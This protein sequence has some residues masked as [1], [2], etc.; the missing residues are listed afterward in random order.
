M[1]KEKKN[2]FSELAEKWINKYL[3]QN[4]KIAIIVNKKW[5]ASWVLCK[6][7][8]HIPKCKN[9]DIPIAY[10]KDNNENQ[11]WICHLCKTQ[12]NIFTSCPKCWWFD[13][14]TYW[15]WT[16]KI[17]EIIY[18]TYNTKPIII[19]SETANSIP[20]I[21]KIKQD[22][23]NSRII[24]WTSLLTTNIKENIFDIMIFQNADIWLN[25]PDYLSNQNN[26]S[27]LYNTFKYNGCNN[28]IVQSFNTENYSIINACKMDFEWFNKK[29]QSYRQEFNYPPFSQICVILYKNEIEEKL[30]NTVNK[31]YQ[32]I[33][34]L[35]EKYELNEQLEIYSTP[36]LIYKIYWKYRYNIIIKGKD[37][38]QFMDIV[39]SKLKISSRWFKIDW[40]PQNII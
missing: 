35:K 29:E 39:Y 11:F 24:I 23:H 2:I 40:N 16:Q 4:K 33:L 5:Y 26:F 27:L 38:R 7:C 1:K 6:D 9:C 10:H 18:T 31:L 32:E 25:I 8:W 17:S 28:F 12:Y 20:K 21:N 15:L 22:I 14:K 30:F 3:K 13:I 34:F 37:I 36:P 19:E